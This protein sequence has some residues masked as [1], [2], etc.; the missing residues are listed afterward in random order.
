[1]DG[2]GI[3]LIGE[4]DV[5]RLVVVMVLLLASASARADS[6]GFFR[7]DDDP[8]SLAQAE[9]AGSTDALPLAGLKYIPLGEDH[10]NSLSFGAD[11]REK[12]EAYDHPEF[13]LE[14]VESYTAHMHRLLLNASL[15]YEQFRLFVELGN[16]TEYG[17]EPGPLPTDID[18]GDV[19]QAFADWNLP[20]G[21]GEAT[22]RVGRQEI[23]FGE[24]LLVGVRDGPNIRQDWDGVRG[25]WTAGTWRVDLFGVRPVTDLPGYWDDTT[26]REEALWGLYLSGKPPALAPFSLDAYYFG[27]VDDNLRLGHASGFDRRSTFGSRVYGNSGA[28]DMVAELMAQTG[29]FANRDVS[30]LAVHS[31]FGWT[32]RAVPWTPRFG[33]KLDAL[34]GN[35]NPS[36]GTFSGFNPLYPNLAY[37]TE[38]TI[39]AATNLVEAGALATVNPEA[40]VAISYEIEALWRQTTR[41]ALYVGPLI[42]LVPAGTGSNQSFI[43]IEQQLYA[44]WRINPYLALKSSLVHFA[45]GPFIRAAHGVDEDY[46][47]FSASVRF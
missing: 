28:F 16:H 11:D 22:L 44:T 1:V 27:S 20:L 38:A 15:R 13:G 6:F 10:D 30:A 12:F 14:H 3:D 33:I 19:Q 35:R 23:S 25:F 39:E 42:P 4:K 24:G 26:S 8:A 17:R 43:G 34:S 47:M 40:K 46:A 45:V 2:G 31:E 5:L 41:D 21:G 18:R 29:E 36:E 32:L 37:S 9:G 7:Y